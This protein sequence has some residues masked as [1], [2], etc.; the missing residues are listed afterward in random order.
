MAHV[1]RGAI[2]Y[3]SR[4]QKYVNDAIKDLES[5]LALNKELSQTLLPEINMI[6]AKFHEEKGKL[7]EALKYVTMALEQNPRAS[8]TAELYATRA[9]L[10]FKL[11]QTLNTIHDIT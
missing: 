4:D 8:N 3:R 6:L 5:A 2:Y 1:L 10:R 9:S 11:G 7:D